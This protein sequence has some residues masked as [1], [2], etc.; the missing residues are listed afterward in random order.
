M[1]KVNERIVLNKI[2]ALEKK[3]AKDKRSN[4]AAIKARINRL[5]GVIK[6]DI[7]TEY[8]ERFTKADKNLRLLNKHVDEL[9]EKYRSFI[10]NRQAAS[11]SFIGYDDQI[12]QLKNRIRFADEKINTLLARQG[13]MLELMSITELENRRKRIEELQIKARFS[14]A[15]SYDR[16][17]KKEQN[18]EL[19]KE[20]AK[21]LL[22]K[23]EAEAEDIYKK[24]LKKQQNNQQ[25]QDKKSEN[26]EKLKV[27]EKQDEGNK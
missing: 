4:T 9:D 16:A 3:H 22:L 14:L 17:V 21:A 11:Q 2:Y 7:E 13:H 1:A 18:I 26:K 8:Q 24:A 5:K 19:E 6:W 12:R 27:K 23:E 15:E 10:R 20:K 25:E